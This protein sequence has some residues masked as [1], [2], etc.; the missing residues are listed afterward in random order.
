M[1]SVKTAL[2]LLEAVSMDQPIRVGELAR[3]LDLPKST[4]QRGLK[5]LQE[6]G[7]LASGP[8]ATWRLTTK[9]F[10]VGSRFEGL[11]LRTRARSVMRQVAEQTDE[12]VHLAV[13]DHDNVTLIDKIDSRRAVR[14]FQSLGASAPLLASSTGKAIAAHL[15]AA[16]REEVLAAGLRRHTDATIIDIAAMREHLETIRILGYAVNRGEWRSDVFAIG[17]PL[18]DLSDYPIAAISIS[19]PAHR[20]PDEVIDR[21]G[22]MLASHHRNLSDTTGRPAP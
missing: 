4:A 22:R 9:A 8:D 12:N 21:Y 20:L 15:P 11:D 18:L 19:S 16:E 7:W 5:T 14:T 3:R 2:A 6:A 17:A 1:K 13:R 10:A